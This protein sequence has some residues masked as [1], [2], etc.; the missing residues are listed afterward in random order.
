ML[1]FECSI[2]DPK[3]RRDSESHHLRRQWI[4]REWVQYSTPGEATEY[5][6]VCVPA[7]SLDSV[8]RDHSR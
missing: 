2:G 4:N 8:H 3:W 1:L 6:A 5:I 7:F